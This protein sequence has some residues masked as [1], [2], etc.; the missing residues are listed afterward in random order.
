MYDLDKMGI[1]NERDLG[2]FSS[3]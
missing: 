2:I 3:C 1:T